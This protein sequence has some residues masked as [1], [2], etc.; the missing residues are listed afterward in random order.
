VGILGADGAAAAILQSPDV[1]RSLGDVIKSAS[2]ALSAHLG[3]DGM[4]QAVETNP[5][6]LMKAGDKFHQTAAVVKDLLGDS[7]G[8]DF[9]KEKPRLLQSTPT[10][11]EGNIQTLCDEFDR[12]P[13]MKAV[14]VRPSLLYDRPTAKR[15]VKRGDLKNFQSL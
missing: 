4:L 13:V 15:A 14:R 8:A 10:L 2:E 12:E 9:L 1:L 6:L 3:K 5:I 11:I 7:E